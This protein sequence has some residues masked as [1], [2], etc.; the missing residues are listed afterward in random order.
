[1]LMQQLVLKKYSMDSFQFYNL[2]KFTSWCT[3][4]IPVNFCVVCK[5]LYNLE[6]YTLK[7]ALKEEQTFYF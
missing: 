6:K 3:S 7:N 2:H 4:L 1:M 5:S